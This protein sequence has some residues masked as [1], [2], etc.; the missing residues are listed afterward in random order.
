V[1]FH[2]GPVQV[3][4][5]G[6]FLALSFVI[7]IPLLARDIGRFLAP[8]VGISPREAFQKTLDLFTWII[9]LSVFGARLFYAFENH[10]EF[11]G[12]WLAVLALWDGGLVYYGGLFGAVAGAYFF[13]RKWGWPMARFYDL[14]AAY[15]LL[16]HA[17]GR[18]GCWFSGCC[19][20]VVCD[21]ARG[22]V[23]PSV[24]DGL[25]RYPTQLWEMAGDFLLFLAILGVRRWTLKRP[26]MTFSLYGLT[27]GILRFGIEFWRRGPS[28]PRTLGIFLSPSQAVSALMVL[29]SA[30][31]LLWI[32]CSRPKGHT[33]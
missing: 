18:V 5:Y 8:D 17:I 28:D 12:R 22:V 29:A 13:M 9:P 24:G 25:S 27:Y 6:F 21:A 23:F 14:A 32:A 11:S 7:S 3:Y 1:L 2:L 30:I 10:A 4:S 33:P 20:G 26:W 16:G 15:I 31:V 19:Y